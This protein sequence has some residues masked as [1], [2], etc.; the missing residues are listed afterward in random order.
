MI[1]SSLVI[2]SEYSDIDLI[3]TILSPIIIS[4]PFL[5]LNTQID[6][7]NAV[8]DNISKPK[9]VNIISSFVKVNCYYYRAIPNYKREKYLKGEYKPNVVY[10]PL[11][12]NNYVYY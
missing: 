4:S 10:K 1:S 5:G 9:T 8:I 12:Y 6:I 7:I 11:S 2:S 3:V